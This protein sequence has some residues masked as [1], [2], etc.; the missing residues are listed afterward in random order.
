MLWR[1]GAPAALLAAGAHWILAYAVAGAGFLL[2]HLPTAGWKRLP[3]H[4]PLTVLFTAAYL[5]GGVLSAVCCHVAHN[6]LLHSVSPVRK[7]TAGTAIA[8]RREW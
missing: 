7:E 1:V 3:Y 5:G 8:S 6:V 4:A 2:L